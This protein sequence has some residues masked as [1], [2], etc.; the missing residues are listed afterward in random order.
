[1]RETKFWF[2]RHPFSWYQKKPNI[3]DIEL[4][5]ADTNWK[6]IEKEDKIIYYSH[7]NPKGI[8]GLFM[9]ISDPLKYS[10]GNKKYLG[11]EIR[12]LYIPKANDWPKEIIAKEVVGHYL[13][14]MGSIFGLKPD[15][16]SRIKSFLLG[17]NEPSNHEGV[18][19]LFCKIHQ[20]IGYPLI[21]KIRQGYPDAIVKDAN[22]KAKRIEFEFDSDD[23]RKDMERGKHDPKKCDVI[24]CWKNSWGKLA[25]KRPIILPLQ[26]LYGS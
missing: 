25:P 18:V 2:L 20:E 14:P 6:N 13:Q 5:R 22:G 15:E 21:E 24:V 26:S 7:E 23:F 12:P 9:A 17:M 8:I 11:Y 16:Y 19:A 4:E 3:I 1:M 10:A